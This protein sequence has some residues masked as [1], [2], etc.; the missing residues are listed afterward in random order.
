MTD[1]LKPELRHELPRSW[2]RERRGALV[3]ELR[4]AE[5]ARRRRRS[6]RR[7]LMVVPAAAVLAAGAFAVS[8]TRDTPTI[9]VVNC[10][11]QADREAAATASQDRIDDPVGSCRKEWRAGN[12]APTTEA[13]PLVACIAADEVRVYPGQW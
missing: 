5:R 12:V 13:P 11:P 10:Y 8:L 9:A 6:W 2:V 1:D 4:R 7:G 3:S